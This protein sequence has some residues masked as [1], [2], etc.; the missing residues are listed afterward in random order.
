VSEAKHAPGPWSVC[1]H[2]HPVTAE[3][4]KCGYRGCI[5]SADGKTM[6]C[7]LGE[8]AETPDLAVGRPMPM[9]ERLATAALIAAAP[10]LLAFVEATLLFH[11]GGDWDDTKRRRWVE[12]TGSDDATTKALCDLGRAVIGEA[13]GTDSGGGKGSNG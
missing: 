5:L 2:L 11:S 1:L 10:E 9:G 4:C 13:L 6:V 3:D 12:L 7:E 8:P